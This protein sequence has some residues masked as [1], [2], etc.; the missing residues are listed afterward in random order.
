MSVLKPRRCW[1]ITANLVACH[2]IQQVEKKGLRN[3][4]NMEQEIIFDFFFRLLATHTDKLFL[5]FSVQVHNRRC[6]AYEQNLNAQIYYVVCISEMYS[7]YIYIH[8]LILVYLFRYTG[9]YAGIFVHHWRSTSYLVC[10]IYTNN[11]IRELIFVLL[12]IFG[13]CWKKRSC[14]EVAPYLVPEDSITSLL[15]NTLLVW[16]RRVA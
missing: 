6:N 8:L 5:K 16:R 14:S 1:Y 3:L 12:L 9:I 11:G 2:P 7:E 15:T 4:E 13:C 10:I